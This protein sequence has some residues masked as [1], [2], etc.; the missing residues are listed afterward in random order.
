MAITEYIPQRVPFVMV[1][2][3][4]LSN[5]TTAKS[6]YT[7]PAD[8]VLLSGN[9]LSSAGILENVA[10]TAA[11][12]IGSIAY[13]KNE[14]IRIGY[15]GAVKKMEIYRLPHIGEE[16]STQI[17]IIATAFDI[18]LVHGIVRV[19]DELISEMYLKIALQ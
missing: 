12:W 3:L 5:D 10:Q 18:S 1:D 7:I 6:K 16:L 4:V 19:Y 11:A 14:P 2:Q 15:I 8:N 13:A 17:D 9:L